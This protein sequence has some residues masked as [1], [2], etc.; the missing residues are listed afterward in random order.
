MLLANNYI[1][2]ETVFILDH[3]STWSKSNTEFFMRIE[4]DFSGFKQW[5]ESLIPSFKNRTAKQWI[6]N[7][8]FEY[9]YPISPN[10]KGICLFIL[11]FNIYIHIK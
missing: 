10:H 1:S 7:C 11:W 9:D 4:F 3:E 5:K 2:E 8:I 6:K